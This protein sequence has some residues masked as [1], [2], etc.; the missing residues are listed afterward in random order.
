MAAACLHRNHIPRLH[1]LLHSVDNRPSLSGD[2]RPHLISMLVAVIA[3]PVSGM[4]R[5]PDGL[6]L[7]LHVKDTI[8]A[9][10]FLRKANLLIELLHIILHMAGALL[11]RNQNPV[12]AR[13]DHGVLHA[14]DDDRDIEVI[15]HMNILTTVIHDRLADGVAGHRLRQR[16]PGSEVL[17]LACEPHDRNALLTFDHRVIK[18]DLLQRLIA[19]E[20]ILIVREIDQLMRLAKHISETIGKN[21]TVPQRALRNILLRRLRVRLLLEGQHFANRIL[22]LGDNITILERRIRRLDAH[23]GKVRLTF[24]RQLSEILQRSEVVIVHKRIHRTDHHSL[25]LADTHHVMK[26]GGRQSDGG[27]SVTPARLHRDADSVAELIQK[28]RD[29]RTGGGDCHLRV[30]IDL[31]DLTIDTLN[32]GF[33]G[34]TGLIFPT[35]NLDKLFRADLIGKRPEPLAGT[36]G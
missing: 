33:I 34:S 20:Q 17:P 4:N 35:E 5:H 32:H 11:V 19:V 36:A 31:T 23:Q 24:C 27:E 10:G 6:A 15:Y 29:L 28:I 26:V 21:A 9:P 8:L 18:A 3:H 25:F 16:I 12:R 7:L 30:R 13:R 1:A 2:D 14:Q 22:R